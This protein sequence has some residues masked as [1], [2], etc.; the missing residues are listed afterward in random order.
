MSAVE[1]TTQAEGQVQGDGDKGLFSPKVVL[2][3]IVAG[4]FAFSAFVVLSTYAPDLQSGD[5]GRAHALSRSAIGY[6]GMVR[7]LR[8]LN[9][10][11]IVSRRDLRREEPALIVFTPESNLSRDAYVKAAQLSSRTLVVLPKWTG[12]LD[13]RHPGWVGGLEPVVPRDLAGLLKAIG[14]PKASTTIDKGAAP[15]RLTGAPDSPAEGLVLE[16]GPIHNLQT[17]SGPGLTPVLVDGKGRM[18]LARRAPT[19]TY[20]LADPDL[21]NTMGL[22]DV[23]TARAGVEIL[24]A[25]RD[26]RSGIYRRDTGRTI[27]FDATLNGFARSQSLLKLAFEPPFVG[28]TLCLVGAALLMGLHAAAR[29]RAVRR[30]ER[31]LAL[32]KDALIDNSAGLIRMAR[33]EPALAPRYAELQRA[34]AVRALGGARHGGS[35]L[36]GQALT[37]FLDRQGQRFGAADSASA[38]D[39]ETRTVR[40]LGDLMKVAVKWHQW[41]LEMT[42][43]RR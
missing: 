9:E 10:P 29:F 13:P 17:L 41:R 27:A 30:G 43:E 7:L 32:G 42:R 11:V 12:G 4:V 1:T 21:L 38:L 25:L 18:V 28:A 6:G 36:E 22:K 26:D 33:R 35:R 37:D 8:N 23:R 24:R 39:E 31:A 19:E 14:I 3:M 5:N 20:V 2:G 16:T 15:Q 34:A 40:S